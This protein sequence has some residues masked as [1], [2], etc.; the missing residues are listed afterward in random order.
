MN[1]LT[2]SDLMT[3]EEYSEKR[4]V[5]RAQIIRYKKRRQVQVGENARLYFE[6]LRTVQYQIQEVL[7][8][9]RPLTRLALMK[10]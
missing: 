10:N 7:R 8:L 4:T 2:R 5:L 1:K 3:L 6:N 9:K